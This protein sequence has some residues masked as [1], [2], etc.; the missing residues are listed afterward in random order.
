MKRFCLF[1]SLIVVISMLVACGN[2]TAAPEQPTAEVGLVGE[3]AQT[4]PQVGGTWVYATGDEPD[5]LDVQ[6]T[7]SGDSEL[8]MSLVGGTMLAADPDTKE[9]VPYLAESYNV[10][11]DGSL[12]E[13]KIKDGI[14]WHDGTPLTAED[15][16][17]TME[18]VLAN[19]SPATGAMTEGMV[20]VEAIDDLTVQIHMDTP[21]SGMFFG[22]TC[23]YMQPLPKHYIEEVGDEEFG[24]NPIGVGPY[25]FKEWITGDRI[26]LERNPDFNWGPPFAHKGPA[27]IETI[28]IRFVPEYVTRLAGIETGEIDLSVIQNKDVKRIQGLDI[29]DI[30]TTEFKGAGP[31][32]LFNVSKPPFDDILVRKAFNL[33]INRE[34]LVQAVLLGFG[35]PLWGVITPATL[36]HWDG[37]KEIGYGYDL[38]QAKQLMAEAGY[39]LNSEGILEKDGQPLVLEFKVSPSE[40]GDSIKTAEILLEQFK[41]LGVELD[42]RQLEYGVWQ[43]ELTS[44]NYTVTIDSWGWAE[45]QILMPIFHSSMMGGMNVGYVNDPVLDP[46]LLDAYIASNR[47]ILQEKLN[48]AQKYVIEQAF[49]APLYSIQMNYGLSRKFEN[50]KVDFLNVYPVLYDAYLAQ[51]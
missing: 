27:Y 3:P 29:V 39:T 10:S 4:E 5:T 43:S 42:L 14:T 32:L 45:A 23:A 31:Y 46:I 17:F 9:F 44:G 49:T 37:D 25:K 38:E 15:Y 41:A 47:D 28:E 26:I 51:P 16:V 33:A 50:I 20:S 8:V 13:I 7:V 21:N 18:R 11:E 12:W 30:I 40:R 48:E 2:K 34:E 22:L 1:I 36:G 6:R 35:E 19:P 24:R